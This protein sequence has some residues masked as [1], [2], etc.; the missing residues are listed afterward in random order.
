[1]RNSGS[2]HSTASTLPS[3]MATEQREFLKSQVSAPGPR[4]L[5]SLRASSDFPIFARTSSEDICAATEAQEACVED[6]API[7]EACV[8]VERMCKRVMASKVTHQA[9]RRT[10]ELT[11]R[12]RSLRRMPRFGCG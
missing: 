10:A 3:S 12:F 7:A 2:Y 1:A 6:G 9:R 11:M 4:V 8:A 5:S